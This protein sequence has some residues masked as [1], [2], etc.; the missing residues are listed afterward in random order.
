[1]NSKWLLFFIFIQ[2]CAQL[3][4]LNNLL[5]VYEKPRKRLDV[6]VDT[7]ATG[8]QL[9][10]K[11]Y[12]EVLDDRALFLEKELYAGYLK[13]LLLQSG[14]DVVTDSKNA[15]SIIRM[16]YQS[17][18]VKNSHMEP[19]LNYTAPASYT[20]NSYGPGAGYTSTVRQNGFGQINVV[21]EREVVT[22]KNNNHIM[23]VA[24]D[25]IRLKKEIKMKSKDLSRAAIWQSSLYAVSN[26][27]DFR[28]IMPFMLKALKNNVHQME[29][30]RR[31]ETVFEDVIDENSNER[32]SVLD[33]NN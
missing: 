27:N 23:I 13:S 14:Y 8:H 20:V 21:G 32:V 17:G 2:S 26:S 7:I 9:S 29:T 18:T 22:Y 24:L 5:P 15:D 25:K 4:G 12:I 16:A 10:K 31:T 19:I 3:P 11:V 30:I 28:Y 6:S 1:M 33:Q